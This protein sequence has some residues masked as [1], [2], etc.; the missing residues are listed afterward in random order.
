MAGLG[1][2]PST[3]PALLLVS[4]PLQS[5]STSGHITQSGGGVTAA[6]S[7]T[8]SPAP[9]PCPTAS[10]PGVPPG[11]ATTLPCVH[12]AVCQSPVN[13]SPQLVQTARH[14]WGW[15]VALG[16]EAR[17]HTLRSSVRS[18]DA[19][20]MHG[21]GWRGRGPGALTCAELGGRELILQRSLLPGMTCTV[22]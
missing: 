4:P 5:I 1:A 13:M 9:G 2:A 14:G 21:G 18:G 3:W 6:P 10:L 17:R 19:G 7:P 8:T 16:T 20:T 12:R 22:S 15:G 11:A